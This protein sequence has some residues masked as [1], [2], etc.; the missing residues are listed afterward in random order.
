[1]KGL[2]YQLLLLKMSSLG[3]CTSSRVFATFSASLGGY[4]WKHGLPADV[5]F[6][7]MLTNTFCTAGMAP[8]HPCIHPCIKEL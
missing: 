5:T 4:L 1:M 6:I 8:F 2:V 3:V 7:Y